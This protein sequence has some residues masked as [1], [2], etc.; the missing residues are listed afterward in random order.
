M[1]AMETMVLIGAISVL[2]VIALAQA[3]LLWRASRSLRRLDAIDE[4]VAKFGEALTLLTDTTESAFRAVATHIVQAPAAPVLTGSRSAA[5]TA[6]V[7]RAAKRGK[8]VGEIA[9]WE[10]IA[11]GEVRLR[12][13]VANDAPLADAA[14]VNGWE[15]NR[16]ALRMD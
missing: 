2:S 3:I 8:S 7:L 13:Q 14:A 16:G 9:A 6:R 4:R 10:G 12:L 1:V 15:G 11:E 5:R